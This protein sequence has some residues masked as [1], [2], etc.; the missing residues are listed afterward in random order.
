MICADMFPLCCDELPETAPELEAELNRGLR[1]FV[2]TASDPVRV[3]DLKY[4]QLEK[5]TVELVSATLRIEAPPRSDAL[6]AA[7]PA[8]TVQTVT[9]R[10][11]RLS[12][13]PGKV[14]VELKAEDVAFHQGRGSDGK[15]VLLLKNARAG[16]LNIAADQSEIETAIATVARSEAAKQGVAIEQVKLFLDS[17]GPRQLDGEV[18]LRARKLFFTAIIRIFAKVELDQ[19][20]TARVSGLRCNGDGT[21]GSL[22]CGFLAPHLEKM[23]GRTFPLSAFP[24][25]DIRL[26]DV[27]FDVGE[28]LRLTAEFGS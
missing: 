2:S 10:A 16:T 4:P 8:L 20:L 24:L 27:R 17:H 5:V 21:I 6:A 23:E 22:A 1:Q 19:E 12:V 14:D 26:R 25:G 18:H 7:Q 11:E 9:T 3:T 15:I 28:R 13:G